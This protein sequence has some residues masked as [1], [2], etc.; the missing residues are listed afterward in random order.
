M[1]SETLGNFKFMIIKL[2]VAYFCSKKR[3]L[4]YFAS[5]LYLILWLRVFVRERER[6]RTIM[7]EYFVPIRNG[8]E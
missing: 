1:L 3:D 5:I 6:K 2:F 8:M 4:R 7:E